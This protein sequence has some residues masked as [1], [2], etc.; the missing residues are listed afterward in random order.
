MK[1]FIVATGKDHPGIVAAIT[2]ELARLEVNILD[3]S[4]T[5]MKQYFTMII[6]TELPET[7]SISQLKEVM[8]TVGQDHGVLIRV[9]AEDTFDAMHSI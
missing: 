9:Q 2:S 3:L 6:L 1:A 8:D 7:V 4:Q 5:L